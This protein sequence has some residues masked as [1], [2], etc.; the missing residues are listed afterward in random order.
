MASFSRYNINCSLVPPTIAA[1]CRSRLLTTTYAT[2]NKVGIPSYGMLR[3]LADRTGLSITRHLSNKATHRSI[4][5]KEENVRSYFKGASI[6]ITVGDTSTD[7]VAPGWES[8]LDLVCT[9][10]G[11]TYRQCPERIINVDETTLNGLKHQGG[12]CAPKSAKAVSSS[13]AYD[14][15][16]ITAVCAMSYAGTMLPLYYIFE[17]SRAREN[18]ME[19]AKKDSAFICRKEGFFMTE[20]IL[21]DWVTTI[22]TRQTSLVVDETHR[23]LLVTDRHSS[24][25]PS[26]L[27][28]A[29]AIG[30]DSFI[31][32]AALSAFFQLMDRLFGSVKR[33]YTSLIRQYA[34][35]HGTTAIT[36]TIRVKLWEEACNE[37]MVAN[38]PEAVPKLLKEMALFPPDLDEAICILRR[39]SELVSVRPDVL[40]ADLLLIPERLIPKPLAARRERLAGDGSGTESDDDAGADAAGVPGPSKRGMRGVPMTFSQTGT[41]FEAA[42]AAQDAAKE[43]LLQEKVSRKRQRE[44]AKAQKKAEAEQRQIAKQQKA[45][46]KAAGAAAKAAQ[47]GRGAG[48]GRGRGGRGR[49]GRGGGRGTSH[50]E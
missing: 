8:M 40:T 20:E 29:R 43:L 39:S 10:D 1:Y 45:A 33:K 17:G 26:V 21:R 24:R 19:Y 3:R 13:G 48:R 31:S 14:Q 34:C 12:G 4:D 41:E 7:F 36:R 25:T 35:W 18:W 15:D 38:A 32:T 9:P 30:V 22:F 16:Q 2:Q 44:E 37:N 11:K 46:E 23:V 6:T 50:P 5:E 47:P 49:G 28:D 27:R 42:L